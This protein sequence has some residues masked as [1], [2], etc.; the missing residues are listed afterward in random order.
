MSPVE[1]RARL[2]E[3]AQERIAAVKAGLTADHAYMADLEDEVL[4]F[5]SALAGAVVT[6]IAT[7]RGQLFGRDVG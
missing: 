4:E 6:E 1:I 3:L 7:F 2:S 5:R